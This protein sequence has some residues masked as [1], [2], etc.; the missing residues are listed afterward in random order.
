M[1]YHSPD[2]FVLTLKKVDYLGVACLITG[3]LKSI[4]FSLAEE[5]TGS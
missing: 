4:E 2:C 1:S 5:A 3:V